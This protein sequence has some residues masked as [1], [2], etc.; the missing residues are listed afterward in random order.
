MGQGQDG[1]DLIARSLLDYQPTAILDFY[2]IYPDAVKSPNLF[3][4]IHG[5]S[6]STNS[7][8]WK[9][10]EYLP[11]PIEAEGFEINGNGQVSRP[12][13]KIANKDYLMTSLLQN[14]QDFKNAKIIRKR[15]FLKYI[16]DINF[17]GG[18]PFGGENFYAEISS[19]SFL[20]SQKTAENKLFVELELTSPLDVDNFEVNDRK[21]LAKYCYWKYRGQGCNYCGLPVEKE[22]GSPF[23]NAP[24]NIDYN[25]G[26]N[27][28]VNYLWSENKTYAAGNVAYLENKNIILSRIDGDISNEPKYLKTWY[29]CKSGNNSGQFPESNPTYWEKDGCTKTL[30][31]CKKR[32]NSQANANYQIGSPVNSQIY[33]EQSNELNNSFY[34]TK[35]QN[36]ADIANVGRRSHTIMTHIINHGNETAAGIFNTSSFSSLATAGLYG[37]IV[38]G[39]QQVIF[40]CRSITGISGNFYRSTY[41]I[42]I[43]QLIVK[44]NGKSD[45][46]L[47][48]M[49]IYKPLSA[50]HNYLRFTNLLSSGLSSG[51]WTSQLCT[52]TVFP[53]QGITNVDGAFPSDSYPIN[54]ITANATGSPQTNA[55]ITYNLYTSGVDTIKTDFA[56]QT[57]WSSMNQN[58]I[59]TCY[60]S[61]PSLD[62]A[63]SGVV[64]GLGIVGLMGGGGTDIYST[65]DLAQNKV[66]ESNNSNINQQYLSA[67]TGLG[68]KTNGG[69]NR[70][71][72]EISCG[73][74][75]SNS[76]AYLT[77]IR[78]IPLTAGWSR[79]TNNYTC[80]YPTQIAGS[81]IKNYFNIG[82]CYLNA[83]V[84]SNLYYN[85]NG[86]AFTESIE[87]NLDAYEYAK[88][89]VNNQIL[90]LFSG[91]NKNEYNY[92]G[93]NEFTNQIT[94]GKNA[95]TNPDLSSHTTFLSAAVFNRQLSEDEMKSLYYKPNITN[96]IYS[97]YPLSYSQIPDAL[98]AK[99]T[100][101][102]DMT[103][104]GAT[105]NNLKTPSKPLV[106]SSGSN[107][108]FGT[109]NYNNINTV[110]VQRIGLTD[111]L[112]F[113]GFPGTDGF[114]YGA[115]A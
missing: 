5:G 17:D 63:T 56:C 42:N 62:L 97:N 58:T 29:V 31:A 13:I 107:S 12:K 44:S 66:V 28:N 89:I 108:T 95:L 73:M 70:N 87:F 96:N 88:I 7:I 40:N 8:F 25:A 90:T 53:N 22:D 83:G 6:N 51:H 18:N 49:S 19:E 33:Y 41:T 93:Y 100:I 4:P 57:S 21:I 1:K 34:L 23:S 55:G 65:F 82:S 50:P 43:P 32:F 71:W 68:V 79:S 98:K 59:F 54:R 103:T 2:Q 99:L 105:F 69:F 39:M 30:T 38:D 106:I 102:C 15:T 36:A 104:N 26:F 115:G 37:N 114:S 46:A 20:V 113:G 60:V 86:K 35:T 75:V 9:G 45:I 111:N 48:G 27:D 77:G 94:F 47:I 80:T 52:V 11:T 72:W 78:L 67:I 76:T 81:E 16:D 110:S 74:P 92:H 3:I 109:L 84:L 101:Y 64:T 14:N 10:I 24:N 61:Y 91:T 112:N 85:G